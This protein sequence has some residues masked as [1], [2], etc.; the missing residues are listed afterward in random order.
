MEPR[1]REAGGSAGAGTSAGS[2]GRPGRAKGAPTPLH[3]DEPRQEDAAVG[4]GEQ[5]AA[6]ARRPGR[7]GGPHRA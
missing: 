6:E 5:H 3:A 1:P 4:G 2:N 7:Y